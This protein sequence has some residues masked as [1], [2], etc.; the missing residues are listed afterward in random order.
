M[1]WIILL[2]LLILLI[3]LVIKFRKPKSN[4][5]ILYSGAN[6]TGKSFNMTYDAI[7]LYKRSYRKWKAINK[8]I[9]QWLW[10]WIPPLNK[11]RVK[12]ELYGLNEPKLYSTYPIL[13]GK[14]KISINLT[15]DIMLLRESIP[16]G[17]IVVIDEFSS[18]VDQFQYKESFSQVLND[19]IQKWRHY[20]GNSSHLLVADQCTNNIPL[21]VRYRCNQAIVC[22]KTFHFLFVH[23]TDYK[24][25]DITDD[26]K[27]IEIVD[28]DNSDTEDKILKMIRFGIKRRYDD[29]AYSNRYFY[30]DKNE[31]NSKFIIS[32]MKVLKGIKAPIL[33]KTKHK[34]IDEKIDECERI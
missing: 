29:R 27:N 26:I 23:I 30:V 4:T 16:L 5:I 17:S 24:C 10:L 20:H 6:G 7:R 31:L 15:N 8:P 14:N 13:Y 22:K 19:H 33:E 1:I 12:K 21:Q 25:I 28:S 9:I 18:W 34:T 2:L 3:W 11:K 32:K